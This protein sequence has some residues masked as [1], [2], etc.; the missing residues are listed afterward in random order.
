ME[1]LSSTTTQPRRSVTCIAPSVLTAKRLVDPRL[2]LLLINALRQLQHPYQQ[3]QQ[4][5]QQQQQQ[6]RHLDLQ[7]GSWS[8]EANNLHLNRL[9]SGRLLIQSRGAASSM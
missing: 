6:L 3:Q 2:L 4:L 9:R 7:L 5:P 1:W 8:S